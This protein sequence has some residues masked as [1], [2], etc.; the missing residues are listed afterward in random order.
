[1]DKAIRHYY[2]SEIIQKTAL[3]GGV[4]FK[5][6]LLELEN[7][8]KL[9]FR[10][11]EDD[12]R[13]YENDESIVYIPN[14]KI[15]KREKQFYDGLNEALGIL[16]P[17]VEVIDCSLQYHTQPYQIYPYIEGKPL[18]EI[19]ATLNANEKSEY[20]Y[21]IGVLVGKMHQVKL[22]GKSEYYIDSKTWRE[23]NSSRLKE[24]LGFL[25]KNGLISIIEIEELCSYA[26]TIRGDFDTGSFMHMDVRPCNLIVNNGELFLIDAESCEWG[27]SCY[28]L[29]QL[30]SCNML[31]AEFLSGYK[32]VFH[33]E[34]ID[35][36][37]PKFTVYRLRAFA[38]IAD[39][40]LNLIDVSESEKKMAAERFLKIKNKVLNNRR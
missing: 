29:A 17:Q 4:S 24:R 16:C 1:M 39:L 7:G 35:F 28:E 31:T 33:T 37:S 19:I 9:V 10:T 8:K 2:G 22:G 21:K 15:F 6:W 32:T 27:D 26:E 18:S 20:M 30:E 12:P 38:R 25:V 5:T 13:Y 3:E 34:N 40:F 23:L 14:S 36:E 11:G